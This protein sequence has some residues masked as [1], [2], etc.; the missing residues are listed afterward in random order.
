MRSFD[1]NSWFPLFVAAVPLEA[2]L[3]G[4]PVDATVLGA[5]PFEAD[6]SGLR[7]R[8]MLGEGLDVVES[9]TLGRGPVREA[10]TEDCR[11]DVVEGFFGLKLREAIEGREVLVGADGGGAILCRLASALAV[12]VDEATDGAIEALFAGAPAML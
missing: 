9:R 7:T 6:E 11:D 8:S 4:G 5:L 10:P 2:K 1:S 3:G 12:D